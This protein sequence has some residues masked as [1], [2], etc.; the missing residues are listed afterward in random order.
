MAKTKRK[1]AVM[2][3]YVNVDDK[4]W[5][6]LFEGWRTWRRY[7]TEKAAKKACKALAKSKPIFYE[8][9]VGGAGE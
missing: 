1:P 3:R 4:P 8:F 5:L 6:P 2:Y 9:R 7:S